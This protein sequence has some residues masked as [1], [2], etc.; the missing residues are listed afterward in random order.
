MGNMPL[1][2]CI[3]KRKNLSINSDFIIKKYDNST[4]KL[5]DKEKQDKNESNK[6]NDNEVNRST[7]SPQTK[8]N[9]PLPNIVIIKHKKL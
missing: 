7:L 2:F 3:G 1:C 6:K 4:S 9:N 8:F 5:I